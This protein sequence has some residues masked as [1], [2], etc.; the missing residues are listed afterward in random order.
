MDIPVK[1]VKIIILILGVSFI[2]RKNSSRR[3]QISAQ[4]SAVERGGGGRSNASLPPSPPLYFQLIH[5]YF[6]KDDR[7]IILLIG[8]SFM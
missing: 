8:V 7:T 1:D 4:K 3:L 2:W 6:I 5:G